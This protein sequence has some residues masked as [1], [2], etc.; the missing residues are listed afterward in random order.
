LEHS[1][2]SVGLPPA[3]TFVHSPREVGRLQAMHL[4]SH[5]LSQQTPSMQL[6]PA[7]CLSQEQLAD[8]GRDPEGTIE[9]STL[10]AS[11][12]P[13]PLVPSRAPLSDEGPDE[14]LLQPPP[15]PLRPR[16]KAARMFTM[17]ACCLTAGDDTGPG[18][19]DCAFN[20]NNRS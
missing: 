8:F 17:K 12:P 3:G 9:Q 19:D 15:Q 1:A 11:L 14:P 5:L 13:S 7:H 10:M 16:A 18:D 2:G 4:P 20:C 6:P